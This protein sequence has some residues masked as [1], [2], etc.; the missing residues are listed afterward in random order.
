MELEKENI[1]K[2]EKALTELK[3]LKNEYENL[4]DKD[5]TYTK[6]LKEE[7]VLIKSK[8]QLKAELEKE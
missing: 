3:D 6:L 2:T 5:E 7:K 8:I 4:K 1:I